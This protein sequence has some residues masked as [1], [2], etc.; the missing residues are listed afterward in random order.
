METERARLAPFAD[1]TPREQAVLAALMDGV[2][3][4]AIAA[5]SGAALKTVRHQTAS[6]MLKLGVRSQ[7]AAV[8]LARRRGW[9]LPARGLAP[10]Q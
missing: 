9:T 10:A 6:I 3:P 7:L 1:L 4:A 8:A 5:A 2:A